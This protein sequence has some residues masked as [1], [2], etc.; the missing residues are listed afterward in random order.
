MMYS[1]L[2]PILSF[3]LGICI[4]F[5]MRTTLVQYQIRGI[6]NPFLAEY[7]HNF[8]VV[9]LVLLALFWFIPRYRGQL[10]R[11]PLLPV[12]I[13][14]ILGSITVWDDAYPILSFV[15]LLRIL[16]L[17]SLGWFLV[18]DKLV[19]WVVKGFL[20]GMVG[21][22]MVGLVQALR[23]ESIGL[24]PFVEPVLSLELAGVAKAT[25]G[26]QIWL[27]AA[28]TFPHPNIF[29]FACLVA[30]LAAIVPSSGK[31]RIIW[32]WSMLMTVLIL[33]QIDHYMLTSVQGMMIAWLAILISV[34][35]ELPILSKWLKVTLTTLFLTGIMLAFSKSVLGLIIVGV[36]GLLIYHFVPTMFHVEHFQKNAL[37]V[38]FSLFSLIFVSGIAILGVLQWLPTIAKRVLY[39]N[40]SVTLLSN[41]WLTGVG[42]SQFV[43]F[44][45]TED[46]EFWQFQPVHNG[47]LLILV[48]GGV[49]AGIV[50]LIGIL[51]WIYFIAIYEYVE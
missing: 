9:V 22:V 45:P 4:P 16:G 33:F 47:I 36:L 23:Q 51:Y 18:R 20:T 49:L 24:F 50:V 40:Y 11:F 28:G 19:A 32:R 6:D 38:S 30:L 46:L 10:D 42:L 8:D 44:L 31:I 35:N 17:I 27:R 15:F 14:G 7:I 21:Q 37:S 2:L 1:R 29:A 26:S 25:L 39:V 43:A 41:Q 13:V 48:E 12:A 34:T 3:G 5:V